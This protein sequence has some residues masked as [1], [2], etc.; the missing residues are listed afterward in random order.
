MKHLDHAKE[1]YNKWADETF[2][3]QPLKT[4]A[5]HIQREIVEYEEVMSGEVID[6]IKT[7]EELIDCWFIAVHLVHRIETTARETGIDIAH[8]ARLKFKI[9]KKRDWSP[10]DAEGV[11]EHKR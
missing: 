8:E 11:I 4:Q 1:I 3:P 9:L 10:P 2:G 5:I 6:N 7:G